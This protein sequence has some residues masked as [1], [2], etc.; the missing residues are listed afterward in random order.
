VERERERDA[1]SGDEEEQ[2]GYERL[3]DE[4]EH[5]GHRT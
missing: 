1:Q 2:Q 4:A 5:G 3:D